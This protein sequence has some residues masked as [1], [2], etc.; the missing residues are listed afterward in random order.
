MRPSHLFIVIAL[1]L[2]WSGR[3]VGQTAGT[4][5]LEVTVA[6]PSGGV[7]PGVA[8]VI[9]NIDTNMSGT[10]VTDAQGRFRAVASSTYDAAANLATVNVTSNSGFL[11]P[12]TIGNTLRHARHADWRQAAL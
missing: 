9:R 5:N 7:L 8:V 12:T 10:L 6:D 2:A 3:A 11:V 1:C 4:G